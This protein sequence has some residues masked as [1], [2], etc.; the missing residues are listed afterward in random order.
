M[1]GIRL[2]II[3]VFICFAASMQ[4]Q[5][6]RS[7]KGTSSFVIP[8]NMTLE[9]AETFAVEQAKLKIIAEEFGT[10]VDSYNTLTI[11]NRNGESQSSMV[12]F[13]DTDVKGEWLETTYGPRIER[14]VENGEFVLDVTIAGTIREI[15]S[16][17][18]MFKANVLRNGVADNCVSDTFKQGD[19]MYMSFQ[20]PEDGYISIYITD[21]KD[22]QCLFP[23]R[24]L[25][26]E[27]MKVSADKRY[28][29]FSKEQSGDIDPNSV[30]KCRLGCA[31]DN[32][33]NRIYLIFS[34]NKYSKAVDYSSSEDKAPRHLSFEDFHTWFSKLRRHDKELTAKSF[35]ITISK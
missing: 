8:K 31:E 16:A 28:V 12:T 23:Y 18:V 20:S 29:F 19:N 10:I 34:P 30:I 21:G 5:H 4:A 2:I 35:F 7:S 25:S 14:K 24:G 22:V 9:Q 15:V 3:S 11:S 6:T 27:Y 26:S 17:P 13:G 33:L 1:R 32:E